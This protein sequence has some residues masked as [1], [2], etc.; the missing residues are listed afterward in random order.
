MK[1]RMAAG[2][3]T[4]FCFNSL[5]KWVNPSSLPVCG[6]AKERASVETVEVDVVVHAVHKSSDFVKD[7][8]D[9]LNSFRS[10]L[11]LNQFMR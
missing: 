4:R 7:L 2:S 11:L 5:W 8:S 1:R 6:R 10:H 9:I 3:G